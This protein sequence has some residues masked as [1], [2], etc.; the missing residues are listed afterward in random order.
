MTPGC[1]SHHVTLPEP[2]AKGSGQG[3]RQKTTES[4]C[5]PAESLGRHL[6]PTVS[7]KVQGK[8]SPEQTQHLQHSH[9]DIPKTWGLY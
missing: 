2:E 8:H 5:I 1:H 9:R 7:P 4:S 3:M 6:L